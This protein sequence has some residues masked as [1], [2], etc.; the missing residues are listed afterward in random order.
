MTQFKGEVKPLVSSIDIFD[1]NIDA[2]GSR[3]FFCMSL[4]P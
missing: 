1:K 3:L 2:V 4:S